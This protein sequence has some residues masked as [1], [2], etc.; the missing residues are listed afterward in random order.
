MASVKGKLVQVRVQAG[1]LRL[2]HMEKLRSPE[3]KKKDGREGLPGWFAHFFGR[4]TLKGEEES[5]YLPSSAPM[6]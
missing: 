6:G 4:E 1:R 3:P 2:W 5:K